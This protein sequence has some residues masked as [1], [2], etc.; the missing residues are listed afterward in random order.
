M[1]VTEVFLLLLLLATAWTL[2]DASWQIRRRQ[3]RHTHGYADGLVGI[4]TVGITVSLQAAE[5]RDLFAKGAVI[6]LIVT[7]LIL[8]LFARK[9]FPVQ[10]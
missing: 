10:P 2:A 6:T 4:A 1:R 8:R 3:A 7:G 5:P 9:W